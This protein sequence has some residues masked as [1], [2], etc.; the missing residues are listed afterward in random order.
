MLEREAQSA[1]SSRR[2]AQQ[3]TPPAAQPPCA[4]GVPTHLATVKY[5]TRNSVYLRFTL[6]AKALAYSPALWRTP[7]HGSDPKRHGCSRGGAVPPSR[8]QLP[9][10]VYRPQI[11]GRSS[12]ER[13]RG[14]RQAFLQRPLPTFASP[15]QRAQAGQTAL[16]RAPATTMA[17]A[18]GGRGACPSLEASVTSSAWPTPSKRRTPLPCIAAA[19]WARRGCDTRWPPPRRYCTL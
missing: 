3:T 2:Q 17:R 4:S 10:A 9:S 6:L 8:S 14:R 12:C 18:H 7:L 16:Q 5:Q 13:A 1:S 19:G 15:L 11:P